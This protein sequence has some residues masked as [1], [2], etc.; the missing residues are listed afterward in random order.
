[1]TRYCALFFLLLSSVLAG[2]QGLRKVEFF[3]GLAAARPVGLG[4]DITTQSSVLIEAGARYNW[5]LGKQHYLV[6]GVS[7]RN[8]AYNV[9]GYFVRTGGG[10]AFV[11]TPD[12]VKANQLFV[13]QY[14]FDLGYRKV[15]GSGLLM[16]ADVQVGYLGTVERIYKIGSQKFID[17]FDPAQNLTCAIQGL[18]GFMPAKRRE[19]IDIVFGYQLISFSQRNGFHPLVIGI[20]LNFGF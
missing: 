9:E 15:L 4:P 14:S 10:D 1:M 12:N 20:R 3:A 19:R 16:G 5:H 7:G 13:D 18:F 17:D 11:I 8:S 2:A 6:L